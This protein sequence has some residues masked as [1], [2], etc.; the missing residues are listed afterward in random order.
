MVVAWLE[1]QQCK[2]GRKELDTCR[3][4]DKIDMLG[5]VNQQEVVGPKVQSYQHVSLG[6]FI[7]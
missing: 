6:G 5:A 2:W 7:V 1:S 4:N 3:N